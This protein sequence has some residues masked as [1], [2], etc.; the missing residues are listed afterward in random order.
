VSIGVPGQ[1]RHER[2]RAAMRQ[3]AEAVRGA[4]KWWGTV[5]VGPDMCG[6]VMAMGA[7]LVCPG[8]DVKVMQLGVR[9]LVKT[10]EAAMPPARPAGT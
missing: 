4:G 5:A 1:I 3:V 7:R 2:V 6:D 10:F 8:G 9:E